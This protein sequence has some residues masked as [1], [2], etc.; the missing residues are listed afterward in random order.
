MNKQ[1]NLKNIIDN[2]E[3]LLELPSGAKLFQLRTAAYYAAATWH[4]QKFKKFPY[5]VL[6][7][8]TGVGKS[9][10]L[11]ALGLFC[12]SPVQINTSGITP[13]ALRDLFNQANEG[14][15]LLEEFEETNISSEMERYVNAR[16]SKQTQK[17]VKMVPVGGRGWKPQDYNTY[18]ATI[19]HRREHFRDQA[20]ENRCIWLHIPMNTVRSKDD[21][22]SISNSI[23][24]DIIAELKDVS[25]ITLPDKAACPD[26]IA[27]RV[28]ETYTP[29]LKL[30]QLAYDKSYM[31]ELYTHMQIA[32]ASFKDGQTYEPK[33]LVLRG[34]IA[35]L[36]VTSPS[37]NGYLDLNSS[38]KVTEICKH[39]QQN[40]Q[41]GLNSRQASESLRELGFDVKQSGGYTKV[42][43][44]TIPQLAKA[45]QD[46]GINDE[47]VLKLIGGSP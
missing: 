36:T 4:I 23:V 30:A 11:E 35:C 16:Y 29:I 1:E 42:M 24:R 37:G 10:L 45:C 7:G 34:L 18:G 46:T 14:T 32:N 5:L 41:R 15:A 38:V 39:L 40:Y 47:L 6:Y 25:S 17:I 27:P 13:P 43:T 20:L 12:K 28:A 9:D 22:G 31:T 33:A 21:Y 2:I 8:S 19:M 26:G 3:L 44:I